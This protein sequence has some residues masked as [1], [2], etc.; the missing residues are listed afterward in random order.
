VL[1]ENG[2]DAAHLIDLSIKLDHEADFP[3]VDTLRVGR[4]LKQNDFALSLLRY[5][6]VNH[7]Y[8]FHVD[9]PTRQSVCAS[10]GISYEKATRIT[11]R[12]LRKLEGP[13]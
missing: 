2:S 1:E 3:T 10:L 8:M 4:Q 6:V 12:E 7:F 11:N 5:L 9:F 13:R